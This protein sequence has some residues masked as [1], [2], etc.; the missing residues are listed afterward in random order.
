METPDGGYLMAG[1]T[2]TVNGASDLILTKINNQFM[3]EWT[4]FYGDDLFDR[5]Y[6]MDRTSDGGCV[7][8]GYSYQAH[9]NGEIE[10]ESDIL[11]IKTDSQ[12]KIT[13]N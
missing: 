8:T 2:D 10:Q 11:V 13:K 9:V 7:I 1:S 3:A 4:Q 5:A 12:G 6:A